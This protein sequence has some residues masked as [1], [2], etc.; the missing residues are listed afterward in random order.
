MRTLYS[1]SFSASP[2]V[3]Y[4]FVF[5]TV[6]LRLPFFGGWL[7]Y[8][9]SWLLQKERWKYVFGRSFT[10]GNNQW[11]FQCWCLEKDYSRWCFAKL[12]SCHCSKFES[13]NG[14]ISMKF[15]HFIK[16]VFLGTRAMNGCSF[17]RSLILELITIRS[18]LLKMCNGR[19]KMYIYLYCCLISFVSVDDYRPQVI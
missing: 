18:L 6:L 7:F 14:S 15:T 10:F 4:V 16:F 9:N 12:G 1:T 13:Q 3:W 8:Y 5:L 17:F 11:W 19:T 2:G